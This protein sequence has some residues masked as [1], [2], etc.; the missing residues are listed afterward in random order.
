MERKVI[1][2]ATGE[3]VDLPNDYLAMRAIYEQGSPDRPLKGIPPTAIRD[4]F[5]GTAGTPVAYSL[6]SGAIRLVP[7]PDT[8]Y[9]LAMDYW[10]EIEPL[11]AF[12]PS[13]WL[14]Q[15]HPDAYLYGSLFQAEAYLDNATRA[16]QWKG[17]LDQVIQRINGRAN[18]DRYGA[19]PLVPTSIVQVR[20]AKC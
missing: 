4:G 14:L 3:D 10:A 8:T 13:N 6:V 11:S 2:N 17:L 7:P 16:S 19:G 20:G 1:G 9:V 18:D 5:D 12:A 15:K